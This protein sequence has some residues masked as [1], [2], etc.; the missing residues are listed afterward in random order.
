MKYAWMLTTC[1]LVGLAG[2][3]STNDTVAANDDNQIVCDGEAKLG[4]MI[5]RKSCMTKRQAE[6]KKR[7]SDNTIEAMR[8]SPTPTINGVE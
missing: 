4:S 8:S 3:K 6:E 5:K 1:L 2:C 7:R